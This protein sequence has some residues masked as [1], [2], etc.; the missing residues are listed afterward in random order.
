MN[1]HGP[2]HSALPRDRDEK[3]KRQGKVWRRLREVHH[4]QLAVHLERVVLVVCL[5]MMHHSSRL[6]LSSAA[7]CE[8]TSSTTTRAATVSTHRDHQGPSGWLSAKTRGKGKR[9][10]RPAGLPGRELVH[11]IRLLAPRQRTLKKLLK[12]GRKAPTA[13]AQSA[14]TR[15]VE[16]AAAFLFL[17]IATGAASPRRHGG[18]V[19]PL[20]LLRLQEQIA[21]LHLVIDFLRARQER[22]V[23][24]FG[25]LKAVSN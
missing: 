5:G 8:L 6:L 2:H 25:R 12:S 15:L 19:V 13:N 1:L 11:R 10:N 20:F 22:R 3:T 4:H 23:H 18:G 14:T 21:P 17:W 7:Q 16:I 24:I 9:G